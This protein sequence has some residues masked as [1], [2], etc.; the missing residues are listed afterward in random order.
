MRC[1]GHRAHGCASSCASY[2][3]LEGQA[4]TE[5]AAVRLAEGQRGQATGDAREALRIH[6]ET[7]HRLGEA[8]AHLVLG[9][10]LSG[11][12][13]AGVSHRERAR[14]LFAQIGAAEADHV[15]ALLESGAPA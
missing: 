1:R 8:R 13:T 6:R 11:I 2:R 15:A 7:G 3:I 12:D 5:V 14:D 10:A 4:M 9:Q